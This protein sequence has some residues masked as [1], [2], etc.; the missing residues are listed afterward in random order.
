MSLKSL[1]IEGRA[2]GIAVNYLCLDFLGSGKSMIEN[3]RK[4]NQRGKPKGL[5]KSGGRQ[6]GS[7]NKS[8]FSASVKF[9]QACLDNDFD[10]GRELIT[11]LKVRD[12]DYS[13]VLISIMD[14]YFGKVP[15]QKEVAED[16]NDLNQELKLTEMFK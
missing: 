12:L 13:K 1:G 7:V 4:P 16:N 8:T 3:D 6:K 14:Y 5:P 9:Q 15:A 11:S 2:F 10:F